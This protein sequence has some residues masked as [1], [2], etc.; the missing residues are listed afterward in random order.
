MFT[1][2][3][4]LSP[5]SGIAKILGK[6]WTKETSERAAK[7]LAT[8]LLDALKHVRPDSQKAREIIRELKRLGW[9]EE[10]LGKGSKAGEGLILREMENG[11]A[12]GRFLQWH[13]GGGH[14][15]PDPY[16]KFSSGESGTI[17]TTLSGVVILAVPGAQAFSE[18]RW[19]DAGRDVAIEFTPFQ[20]SRM[21]ADVL[22][23]F[24]DECYREIY[25]NDPP[26]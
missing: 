16:W 22:C 10:T 18:G 2:P 3:Y 15:G 14:H 7:R 4:G 21:F 12:T 23:S 19:N 25:G 1:D 24:Y 20:W 6:K 11:K 8:E 13:P 9:V 17:R 5:W 26:Q